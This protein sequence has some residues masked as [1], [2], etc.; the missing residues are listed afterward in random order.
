MS[1]ATTTSSPE[2]HLPTKP[3]KPRK[4]K[5]IKETRPTR[6]TWFYLSDD[7]TK[8]LGIHATMEGRDRSSLVEQLI[9]DNLRRFEMP[10]RRSEATVTVSEI[11][12]D[13]ADD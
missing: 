12:G 7:A 6:K 4:P 9:M 1:L 8:R 10:R 3:R 5:E 11:G 13:P 2:T